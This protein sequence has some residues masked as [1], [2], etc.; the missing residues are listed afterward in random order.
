MNR[1]PLLDELSRRHL[2]CDGAMGTQLLARGL[3]SGDCG[4]AWNLERPEEVGAIHQAYRKAGC[5]LF[6][7]NSFGGSRV[8]LGRHGLADRVVE[9]NCGIGLSLADY[10]VLVQCPLSPLK[11][12]QPFLGYVSVAYPS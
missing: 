3:K 11:N 6:T 2:C 9:F 12:N 5:Q 7:T 8:A 10:E 4:M 1:T